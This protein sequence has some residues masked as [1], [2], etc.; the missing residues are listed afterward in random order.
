MNIYLA[1]FQALKPHQISAYSFWEYYIKNG[2][3]EAGY[4]WTEGKVDW[5]EGLTYLHHEEDFYNWKACAWEIT[6]KTIKENHHKNPISMF[7]CYLYP[8]QV[9]ENA[10][11]EIQKIGIPCV[12][13]YCDNVRE[14]TAA[15][16][17]YNVFDLNWVPEFKALKMYKK[18]NFPHI[19]L[20][21]PMWVEPKY[22]FPSK[23]ETGQVSFIG[24]KDIQRIL[25]FKELESKGIAFKIYGADWEVNSDIE[26]SEKKN[27]S[28]YD[29]L[30]NQ[31]SFLGK[32]G[33]HAYF[34]KL[35]QNK[36]NPYPNLNFH[37]AHKL[38][39]DEYVKIT[40]ESNIVLGVNRY[41]SYLYPLLKP[42]TYSRLRDIEAPMLGAC[43][44]TEYTEGIEK[45]YELGKEIEVYRDINEMVTKIQYLQ[46]NKEKRNELRINSQVRALQEH[47]ISYSLSKIKQH[48]CL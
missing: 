13:F 15:P 14:F 22:R 27:I 26:K 40:K 10:I 5:A 4:A 17:E 30:K 45:L 3:N 12:N 35:T 7:L 42:N 19:N 36:T 11:R 48:L 2:I 41:P 16:K 37:I 39:F 21:M 43:Y 23:V 29:T 24:S 33:I 47:S 46:N 34:R 1:F 8:H 38:D 44:L 31:L 32:F 28:K 6:V 18:A 9:D 25:L 20:P